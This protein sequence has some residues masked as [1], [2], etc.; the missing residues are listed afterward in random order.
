MPGMKQEG[1]KKLML[2]IRQVLEGKIYL[3]EKMSSIILEVFSGSRPESRPTSE[4]GC[5]RR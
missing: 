4:A 5:R 3:S 2:A 1:G